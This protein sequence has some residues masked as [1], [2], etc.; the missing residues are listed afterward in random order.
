MQLNLKNFAD[1]VN[2]GLIP[3]S[4]EGWPVACAAL[5]SLTG[6][7]LHIH[8]NVSRYVFTEIGIHNSILHSDEAIFNTIAL[9]KICQCILW[10]D[11]QNF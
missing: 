1:R 5:K 8:G 6:G 10:S 9:L 4:A 3:S 7:W 11:S 2:L